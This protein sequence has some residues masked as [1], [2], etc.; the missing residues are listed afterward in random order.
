M[1]NMLTH[2]KALSRCKPRRLLIV[3]TFVMSCLVIGTGCGAHSDSTEHVAEATEKQEENQNLE[4]AIVHIEN[5]VID[6]NTNGVIIHIALE[7]TNAAVANIELISRLPNLE[8]LW[9]GCC[10]DDTTIT[11]KTFDLLHNA[12][13]LKK[14]ELCGAVRVLSKEMCRSIAEFKQLESF[15]LC[16]GKCDPEGAIML[17]GMKS[18]KKLDLHLKQNE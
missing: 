18:L 11:T 13:A 1:T 10:A 2:R 14:L 4:E 9:L 12:H 15:D 17:K 8:E 16:Y 7:G 3:W 6:R 5:I